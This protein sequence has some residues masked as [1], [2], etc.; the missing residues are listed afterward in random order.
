MSLG[1]TLYPEHG[2]DAES[3]IKASA[4]LPLTARARGGALILFPEDVE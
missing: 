4:G 3:L 1:I 2:A